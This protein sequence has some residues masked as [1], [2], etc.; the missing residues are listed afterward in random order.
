MSTAS[1]DSRSIDETARRK[2]ESA[3]R[4][5]LP[6]VI[7]DFLPAADSPYFLATLEELVQIDLEMRWKTASSL[8]ETNVLPSEAPPRLES[9]LERFPQLAEPGQR[10]RLLKEEFRIR[11]KYGQRPDPTEFEQRFPGLVDSVQDFLTVPERPTAAQAWPTI[12]GYEIEAVLGKGGMGIVYKARQKR[13]NRTVAL[14]TVLGGAET[15]EL[16]RFLSEAEAVARLQH[17]H[18]VQIYEVNKHDGRP[19]FSM[20]FADEGTLSE[21][22]KGAPPATATDAADLIERIAR[23]VEYAHTRGIVH[24]D[25]KPANILLTKANVDGS[26][27]GIASLR[28]TRFAPFVPKISDFGLAKYMDAGFGLT[29]TGAI[30]GTP[31]YMAPEQAAGK[32]ALIGPATDVHALGIILYELLTGKPPYQAASVMDTLELV[33]TQEPLGP[34]ALQPRVPRD[35]ETICLKCLHKE[36]ARRYSS[37]GELADDLERFLRDEPIK[38]RPVGPS[39]RFW[40]W[41]RRNPIVAGLVSTVA[42]LLVTG[43]V[44]ASYMAWQ[45]GRIAQDEAQQRRNAEEANRKSLNTLAEM[46]TFRGLVA[47]DEN[48]P[49]QAFL[50]FAYGVNLEQTKTEVQQANLIRFR[51]WSRLLSVPLRAFPLPTGVRHAL[52]HPAGDHLLTVANGNLAIWDIDRETK[53]DWPQSGQKIVGAAWS[54]DGGEL[55]IGIEA[56]SVELRRFPGGELLKKLDHADGLETLVY[57][58]DGNLLAF[59]KSTVRVWDR[60]KQDYRTEPLPHPQPIKT[61]TFSPDGKRLATSCLD[62][63]ARLFDLAAPSAPRRFPH[64]AFRGGFTAVP[65]PPVFLKGGAELATI[66][67]PT[68]IAKWESATGKPLQTQDFIVVG[69]TIHHMAANPLGTQLAI[70]GF[71]GARI[72]SDGNDKL[73]PA[74]LRHGNYVQSVAVSPDGAT[75]LT[76]CEDRT[77]RLWSMKDGAPL[78]PGLQHQI[79]LHFA[80]FAPDGKRFVTVQSDGLVRIWAVPLGHPRDRAMRVPMQPTFARFDPTGKY[81]FATGSN[82]ENNLTISIRSCASS[83][84]PAASPRE[85]IC[86]FAAISPIPFSRPT[87]SIS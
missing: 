16:L 56:G 57:S 61:L 32:S 49:A 40:R 82:H 33:R 70:G 60:A 53:I 87:D 18:I 62:N 34:R 75:L 65:A 19:F 72:W 23:A 5:Q 78:G 84:S 66:A 46:Y 7:E 64:I 24:R 28:S 17:P 59:G 76:A 14:K 43:T 51:S 37:A 52:F 38:A 81:V 83:K 12:D 36:P 47:H 25:L 42:I 45:M 21:K 48:D 86:R 6:A 1:F 73:E 79:G 77:T 74:L 13:L 11:C 55:A 31:S 71:S 39:E 3:W 44:V 2:F 9:Y 58:R 63:Q 68:K 15:E 22:L 26:R 54:P 50:W 27:S 10:R 30:V 35:L 8:A 67:N 20:E 4:E 29:Q 69:N 85:R 80:A 41:C